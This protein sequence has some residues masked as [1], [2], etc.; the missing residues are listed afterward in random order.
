V[1]HFAAN[2]PN[3]HDPGDVLVN[4]TCHEMVPVRVDRARSP[5]S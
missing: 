2:Y 1:P 3:P 5:P 4:A